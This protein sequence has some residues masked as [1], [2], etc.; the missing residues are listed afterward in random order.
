MRHILCGVQ[1]EEKSPVEI[2]RTVNGAIT[3]RGLNDLAAVYANTL[4]GDDVIVYPG[5]YDLGSKQI[6]LKNLV[7]WEFH[8]GVSISSTNINGTIADNNVEAVTSWKGQ[9]AISNTNPPG[10]RAGGQAT[11]AGGQANGFTKRIILA[12]ANSRVK[13]FFWHW[14]GLVRIVFDANNNPSPNIKVLDENIGEPLI[15]TMAPNG[16]TTSVPFNLQRTRC[17][18]EH[19]L[20]SINEGYINVYRD[21]NYGHHNITVIP[22]DPTGSIFLGNLNYPHVVEIKV[23]P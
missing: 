6:I 23:Y 17:F 7:N 22:V 18:I 2:L 19:I 5:N 16:V 21:Y 13:N 4:P 20:D 3:S 14:T 8:E 15:W 10:W 9:P 11:P 12:N 1:V